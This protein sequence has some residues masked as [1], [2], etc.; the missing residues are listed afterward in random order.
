MKVMFCKNQSGVRM[1]WGGKRLEVKAI[2]IRFFFF[3]RIWTRDSEELPY[4]LKMKTIFKW[5][6]ICGAINENQI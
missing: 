6:Q 4:C 5:S 1:H 3:L 2:S